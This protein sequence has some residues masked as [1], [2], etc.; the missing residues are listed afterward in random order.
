MASRLLHQSIVIPIRPPHRLTTQDASFL[1]GE[2][3]TAPLHFGGFATFAGAIDY[4]RL[5]EHMEARLPLVPRF[6]ERLV[7]AP[8]NLAHPAMEPD[9]DF[10]LTNHVQL[11]E[12]T[13]SNQDAVMHAV[14]RIFEPALSRQ[15]PLWELHLFRGLSAGRSALLWKIHHAIVD[16]VSW[17]QVLNAILAC[18]A[19]EPAPVPIYDGDRSR[20]ASAGALAQAALDLAEM[21]LDAARRIV[22]G[23]PDT[24]QAMGSAMS[25]LRSMIRPT[26]AAPWNQGLVTEERMLARMR[27]PLE[28]V[29]SIRRAFGATLNDV[30]VTI[31][32]EGAA[33]YLRHHGIDAGGRSMR[34]GCP[35]SVRSLSEMSKLGNRVSMMVVETSAQPGD[36]VARLKAIAAETARIKASHESEALDALTAATDFIPPSVMA[37]ASPLATGVIDAASG[38]S[39]RAPAIARRL[40]ATIP[41]SIN[42]IATNVHGPTGPRYVA[43]HEMLD[44]AGMIPLGGNMAYGAVICT[45][46]HQLSLG[47]MA[48][49]R[50]MP[51]V[52]LMKSCV[53]EAFGELM[54]AAE[55]AHPHPLEHPQAA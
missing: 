17:V 49:P 8:F 27:Y 21:R 37:M 38:L 11:H 44:Y 51:D 22:T 52:E 5:L 18:G 48:E 32:A 40:A 47:L 3:R 23:F 36:P 45:Y 15:R 39:A 41:L 4:P 42:F 25:T 30:A 1:Y 34:I 33:R 7:L 24:T 16:G 9:P 55:M 26:I 53:G 43:G 12:L 50:M 19:D 35:V 29:R 46:N 10:K 31:L 28:D 20:R 2:S 13:D 14:M 6:R 54:G